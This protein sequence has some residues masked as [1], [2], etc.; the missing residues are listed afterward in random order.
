MFPNKISVLS[1][2]PTT[3]S[4][5]STSYV[6]FD[7]GSDQYIITG[8]SPPLS[9]R[10]EEERSISL[11]V[12]FD[13]APSGWMTLLNYGGTDAGLGLEILINENI[14][15]LTCVDGGGNN[16]SHTTTPTTSGWANTWTH[17]GVVMTTVSGSTMKAQHWV[18]G[19]KEGSLSPDMLN[20]NTASTV[21]DFGRRRAGSGSL[22]YDGG[23]D[24]VAIFGKA[25]SDAE[26][27]ALYGS[28]NTPVAAGDAS[29]ISDL[30]GYWK[31]ETG[32]G[33]TAYDSSDEGNDATLYNTPTW[34]S[35]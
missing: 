13:G 2:P 5:T 12:K 16:S 25:L 1:Q 9:F 23:M 27:V 6:D 15:L 26:M 32:S 28:D 7:D 24:L 21:I 33:S 19:V 34:A 14:F 11:W 22:H 29:D 10:G 8:S 18:N 3:V 4:P 30:V 31:F 20:I 35:H 17:L